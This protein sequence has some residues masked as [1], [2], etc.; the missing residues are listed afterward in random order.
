MKLNR[1]Y[2]KITSCIL[3]NENFVLLKN[4]IHHGTTKYAHCKRVSYLSYL[5]AKIFKANHRE[6]ARAGLLHDFFYG[7]RTAKEEN[8]Y[9]K[10]PITS[11]QNA[12]KYFNLKESEKH[13]IETHMYHNALFKNM[14]PF[15]TKEEKN[16][17]E[18]YKP[19]S[20]E[21][22]IVCISD[23]LVSLFEVITYKVKYS[24]ALY[25][26]FLMNVIIIK[27]Y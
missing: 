26:I 16:Y 7:S 5:I 21:S 27:I 23:L 22:K 20:K 12:E 25:M 2:K 1:E 18:N 8:S 4:D 6:V 17:F 15:A 11:A 13:I 9:L 10:H 3:N 24:C 19:T 14:L